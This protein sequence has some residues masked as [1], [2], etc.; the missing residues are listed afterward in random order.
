MKFCTRMLCLPALVM[1]LAASC[2]KEASESYDKFETLALGAWMEKY[3][4]ELVNNLQE[5]GGYYV[6]VLDAG[7]MEAKP[8][9]DTICWVKF[10]FSGRDLA[11]NIILTRRA[12]DA[13][14]AGSYT[15]YTHYVPYYRYCG[16]FN[17][18]MIEGSHLAMRN[19]LHLDPAYA[20][21]RGLDAELQ[22]RPGS[23]V[24]LY[25][26]SRVVGGVS[27][28]GGYEGQTDYTL[29]SGKPFIIT[30]E[31]CETIKNPLEAEGT[32]VDD[33]CKLAA[34][35][36]LR[37]YS[38][39]EEDA[40]SVPMPAD[41]DDELHPYHVAE[42]WVSVN[43]T[44]PQVYVN[45][46]YNPATDHITYPNPYSS[47]YEPYNAFEATQEKVRKALV[48]RFHPDEE[49]PYGGVE[50]L[51]DSV[52]LD[53]TAK[54][55]YVERLLDGFIVDT[56]ID[57][58]KEIIYGDVAKK[59][60]VEEYTPNDN[61]R[62]GA[63]YYSIPNLRYG[64][65][66][67]VIT[68]ST[69]GYGATG[70]SGTTSSSSSSSSSSNYYYDYLNY[71]NYYNNYYGNSYYNSYYNNYYYNYYNSYYYNNYYYGDSSSTT[72]TTTTTITTEVPPYTPVL[73]EFYI[74]PQDD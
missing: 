67:A 71:Y 11:G 61:K 8:I 23:K 6:D 47:P 12:T 66:A 34:N 33:F 64:Q 69:Y 57:E 52:K 17:T 29:S 60:S 56:N 32:Q 44:I 9:N 30:M 26:P 19:T 46:R 16:E 37:I 3:H 7:D 48:E 40:E 59:G 70:V 24:T 50:S 13:K 36:G 39:D 45:L 27:G 74:E 5:D 21:A 51:T 35:G 43:D 22:L 15:K 65:W 68:T 4:P 58:V 18:S 28:T 14:L 62:P 38:N 20:A 10:D 1:L 41:P 53:G 31:I 55:W 49:S 73:Y 63:W 42:R 72:T 54:V 2:A 25:L